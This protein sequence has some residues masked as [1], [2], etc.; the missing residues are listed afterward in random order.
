MKYK[1]QITYIPNIGIVNDLCVAGKPI[2]RLIATTIHKGENF[3][4]TFIHHNE[5]KTIKARTCA[6]AKKEVEE[7]LLYELMYA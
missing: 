3:D 2:A 7:Q 5:I 1:W 4:F 6:N